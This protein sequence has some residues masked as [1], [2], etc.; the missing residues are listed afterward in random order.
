MKAQQ[1]DLLVGWRSLKSKASHKLT[2]A[3]RQQKTLSDAEWLALIQRELKERQEANE[4]LSPTHPDHAI[5]QAIIT[6]LQTRL[7]KPL[8]EAELTKLVAETI[9]SCLAK[10]PQDFGAV[11]GKLKAQPRVDM[12]KAAGLVKKT[13]AG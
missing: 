1:P 7:P 12:A 9:K 8:S 5:N 4:Y 2:A 3:G 6:E 11:M 10:S 13:L